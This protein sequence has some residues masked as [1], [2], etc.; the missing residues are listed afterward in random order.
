TGSGTL[1]S[2]VLIFSVRESTLPRCHPGA[3]LRPPRRPRRPSGRLPR[4]VGAV[5]EGPVMTH[6][7]SLLIRADIDL[8]AIELVVTGCLTEQ[9]G[10]ALLAQVARA[11]MLDPASPLRVDLTGAQHIEPRAV[12]VLHEHAARDPLTHRRALR[13]DLPEEH[14]Q[15]AAM[16][17]RIPGGV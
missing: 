2:G 4:R 1:R 10:T 16:G 14:A 15:R 12:D 3:P 6:K 17:Q 5:T 13:V 7:I 11:R 9:A 8:D